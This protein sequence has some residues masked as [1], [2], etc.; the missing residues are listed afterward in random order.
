MLS[1]TNIFNLLL[2]CFSCLIFKGL[3]CALFLL[4]LLLSNY[5]AVSTVLLSTPTPD[6]DHSP[7]QTDP[8]DVAEWL[9]A[10]PPGL[11]AVG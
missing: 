1:A 9:Q 2:I 11:S 8:F 5:K 4:L 10:S 7:E 3:V 6:T